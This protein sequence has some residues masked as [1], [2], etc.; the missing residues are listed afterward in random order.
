MILAQSHKDVARAGGS[1]SAMLARRK[2][3]PTETE[4]VVRL[5]SKAIKQLQPLIGAS[6]REG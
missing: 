1:L 4:N 5:L 6:A 2:F 3:S